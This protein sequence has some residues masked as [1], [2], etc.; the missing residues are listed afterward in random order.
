MMLESSMPEAMQCGMP[1]CK[2]GNM[3]STLR[4]SRRQAT[5]RR[6]MYGTMLA[7]LRRLRDHTL[8]SRDKSTRKLSNQYVKRTAELP[9][10]ARGLSSFV[11]KVG[12]LRRGGVRP[13]ARLRLPL[14]ATEEPKRRMKTGGE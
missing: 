13:G 8:E 11:S 14:L 12:L 2:P 6:M 10:P 7:P 4:S 5:G 1:I 3:G 9:S